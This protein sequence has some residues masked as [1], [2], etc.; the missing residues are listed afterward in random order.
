MEFSDIEE[1]KLPGYVTFTGSLWNTWQ[2]VIANMQTDS[3]FQGN[4]SYD[5]IVIALYLL[6][7]FTLL[8]VMMNMLIA[9]MSDI[10]VQSYETRSKQ[11]IKSHLE[12][13]I[14]KWFLKGTVFGWLSGDDI[15]K[16]KYIICAFDDTNAESNQFKSIRETLLSIKEDIK[17]TQ[18]TQFQYANMMNQ[19]I[20]SQIQ[21][22]NNLKNELQHI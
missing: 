22:S 21:E 11:R 18:V 7:T 8:V 16:I 19:L 17:K 5:Q 12:V 4:R 2:T 6:K 15:S 1:D 3:F 13:V 14:Y 20:S 9:I 10:F